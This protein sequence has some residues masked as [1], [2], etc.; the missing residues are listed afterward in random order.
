MQQRL[1]DVETEEYSLEVYR[2]SCGFVVG[3]DATF[4]DQVC[5]PADFPSVVCPACG[6]RIEADPE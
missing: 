5:P 2:C 3:F 6:M 1:N 4:I